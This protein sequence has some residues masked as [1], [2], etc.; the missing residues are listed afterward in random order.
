MDQRLPP[1]KRIRARH[2][3]QKGF[4]LCCSAL[5]SD[6]LTEVL[7][8]DWAKARDV[9]K[10]CLCTQ[11]G[12]ARRYWGRVRPDRYGASQLEHVPQRDALLTLASRPVTLADSNSRSNLSLGAKLRS[13][14]RAPNQMRPVKITPDFITVAEGSVLIEV[15]QTRVICTATVDAG[16]PSF[17]KGSGKGWVTAEYGMLPR[18]TEQRTTRESSRGRQSGRTLEIS[19]LIGRSLRA[20]TDLEKLGER[21]LWL[22]CDVIQADGGTRTASITGAFIAVALAFERLVAGGML[23]TVPLKDTVAATS[24]GL[25]DGEPTLDLCYEEDARAEVD[26]NVI[27]TGS[28]RFVEIQATAEGRPF[29]GEELDRLL[30][31]AAGG[32]GKLT[33]QQQ[34]LVRMNF[35]TRDR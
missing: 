33:K 5:T 30:G 32:I 13:D 3:A 21:T 25:V 23:R 6:R 12:S 10:C 28:G 20:V 9:A 19:R 7:C 31:L 2:L 1:P 26:M 34:S 4:C 27:M 35:G 18:A 11:V 24:V 16:V 17:L 14:G 29:G 15:G 8:T 22:D